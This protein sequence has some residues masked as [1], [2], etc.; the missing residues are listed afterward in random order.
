MKRAGLFGGTF[1][2]V[3]LGHFTVAEEVLQA[4][5]LDTI[6]LIPSRTPPHKDTTRLADAWARWDMIQAAIS[7]HPRLV[8]SDCELRRPGPSY[9]IDTVRLLVAAMPP[10]TR[11]YLI[12]GMDA[13]LE[14]T[15]WKNWA[16]LLSLIPFIVMTR[17]GVYPQGNQDPRRILAAY[18]SSHLGGGYA[19]REEKRCFAHPE[20]PPIYFCRVSAIDIASSTIRQRVLRGDSIDGLVSPAV[21]AYIKKKGLYQWPSVPLT[22]G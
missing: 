14:I 4:F 1:N 7:D 13:F 2:P 18:I 15:T 20:N 6:V 3:H 8:A 21:A 22:P 16:Q 10:D 17:P 5:H 19:W 9:T 12:V 11:C